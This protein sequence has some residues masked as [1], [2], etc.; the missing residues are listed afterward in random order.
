MS[1]QISRFQCMSLTNVRFGHF[2]NSKT[3]N[4]LSHTSPASIKDAAIFCIPEEHKTL[5][6]II[7]WREGKCIKNVLKFYATEEKEVK[8]GL[9]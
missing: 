1:F 8:A 7:H 2:N 4:W 9:N 6:H 5:F 3:D